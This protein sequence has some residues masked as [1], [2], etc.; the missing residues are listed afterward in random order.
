MDGSTYN[1]HCVDVNYMQKYKNICVVVNKEI[2][3]IATNAGN[4]YYIMRFFFFYNYIII[5]CMYREREW[6]K[7]PINTIEENKVR[8][9]YLYRPMHSIP[10]DFNAA[11]KRSPYLPPSPY[12]AK[13]PSYND[14]WPTRH[15]SRFDRLSAV[16]YKR[17]KKDKSQSLSSLSSFCYNLTCILPSVRHLRPKLIPAPVSRL[18]W[19]TNG[20]TSVH[21]GWNTSVF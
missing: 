21:F 4:M 20:L 9:L 19:L 11:T 18:P 3:K 10:Y 1:F 2:I 5:Y 13:G 16:L 6:E 8:Y 12:W 15:R 17:K 7:N 14:I